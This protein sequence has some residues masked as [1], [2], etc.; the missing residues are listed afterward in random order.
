MFANA[1]AATIMPPFEKRANAAMPSSISDCFAHVDWAHLHTEGWCYGLDHGKLADPGGYGGVPK[2]R[3]TRDPRCDLLEQLQPFPTQT[4]F[5]LH[6]AGSV[7]A[8][9]GKLATNPEPTGSGTFPNTTGIVF[10]AGVTTQR[11]RHRWPP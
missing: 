1:L 7:A 2:D 8:W 5:E 10:V 6:K 9:A 3:R 4:V 11:S